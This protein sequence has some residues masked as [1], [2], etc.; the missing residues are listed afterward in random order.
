MAST[1]KIK[2]ISE[3]FKQIL[4]SSGVEALVRSE[5]EKIAA[6]AE[7]NIS[8]DSEGFSVKTWQGGYGG[9]R[10]IA[11]VTTTDHA[12]RVAEAEDKA[13]TKAVK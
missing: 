13:L 2:F 11:S 6:K 7:S 4:N 9:G 1:M 5:A 8:G 12:S 3:G 10:W